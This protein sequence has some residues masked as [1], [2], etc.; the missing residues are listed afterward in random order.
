MTTEKE[1]RLGVELL[2]NLAAITAQILVDKLG[3]DRDTA[4]AIGD[5]A[6]VELSA[7]W[8]KSQV[9]IPAGRIA[10]AQA[11]HQAVY[12]RHKRGVPV[13]QIR[14]DAGISLQWAYTII[15]TMRK[16]EID[17]K[18]GDIFGEEAA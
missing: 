13:E 6:A 10:K 2:D 7:K 11:M 1:T 4:A 12:Q 16:A 14:R 9:Y 5:Q 15:R 8:G 17:A 18:Q 3:L